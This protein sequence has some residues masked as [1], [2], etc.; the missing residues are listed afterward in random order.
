MQKGTQQKEMFSAA[1]TAGYVERKFTERALLTFAAL[2]ET[3]DTLPW[4]ARGLI[5]AVASSSPVVSVG[6]GPGCCLYGVALF[7]A[8][9]VAP[10]E[11]GD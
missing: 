8:L 6:G 2:R 4:A 7:E 10:R 1:A 11:N 3:H 5:A 9:C